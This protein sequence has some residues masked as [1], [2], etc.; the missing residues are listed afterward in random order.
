[1]VEHVKRLKRELVYKGAILDIYKDTM[2]LPDGNKA[3]WDFVSHRMGAAAILPVMKDGRIVMVRQYRNA[4]ERE[5]LEIPAGCRDSKTEDTAYCAAR[6]MEEET[7]YRS[8]NVKHLLSLRTTVAFCD[9]AVD[10][11]VATDLEVGTRHLDEAESIDVEDQYTPADIRPVS[12]SP[13]AAALYGPSVPADAWFFSLHAFPPLHKSADAPL[14][15]KVCFLPASET[16][17]PLPGKEQAPFH[18]PD[19]NE[20][21]PFPESY[22]LSL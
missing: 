1:M 5:T 2:E 12:V 8:T 22:T 10:I 20:A 17:L 3:E 11:F 18:Y 16:V 6:E 14:H 19:G 7:G 9:E 15:P 4:L 13:A 21:C